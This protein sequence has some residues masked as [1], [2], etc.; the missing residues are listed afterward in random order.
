MKNTKSLLIWIAVIFAIFVVIQ[1]SATGGR[2]EQLSFT[3]FVNRA[4]A[5]KDLPETQRPK[6]ADRVADITVRGNNIDGTLGNGDLFRTTGD[7][8]TFQKDLI[9]KGVEIKYEREEANTWL[10]QLLIN[11]L[12]M[13][14]IIGL[15]FFFITSNDGQMPFGI[16]YHKR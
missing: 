7:I 8:T 4:V 9:G 11:G 2:V 13:L 15:F 3:Q 16:I 10:F 14:V 6:E 5:W 12:P 1:Q